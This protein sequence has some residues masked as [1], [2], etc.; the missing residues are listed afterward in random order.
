M[1]REAFIEMTGQT[2]EEAYEEIKLES[3]ANCM[4]QVDALIAAGW[5]FELPEIV[6][7]GSTLETEP[8]QW[9]WRSPPKRAGS[10]GRK[11]WSTNQAFN[12][13]KKAQC[14]DGAPR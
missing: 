14:P 11:F 7:G 4:P 9:Y 12:A 1:N 3:R 5:R 8:W 2:P 13:L 10:K 6:N